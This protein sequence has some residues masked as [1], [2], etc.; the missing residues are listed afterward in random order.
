VRLVGVSASALDGEQTGQLGLLGDDAV[1]RERLARA[2][3]ASRDVRLDAIRPRRWCAAGRAG[4]RPRQRSR[5][6]VALASVAWLVADIAGD[7]LRDQGVAVGG[8]QISLVE[9]VVAA[10]V[11]AAT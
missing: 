11:T 8:E 1:R 3:T 6:R 9:G 4:T 10:A 2:W 7:R 5:A